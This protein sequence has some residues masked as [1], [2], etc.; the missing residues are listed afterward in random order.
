[1]LETVKIVLTVGAQVL[2]AI[3]LFFLAVNDGNSDGTRI[4][5]AL[6]LVGWAIERRLASIWLLM[7]AKRTE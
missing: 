3:L 1:M 6:F 4:V 7:R 5:A 2:L